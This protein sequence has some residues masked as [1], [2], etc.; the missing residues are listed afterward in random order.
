MGPFLSFFFKNAAPWLHKGG[1]KEERRREG[2]K[3]R[4]RQR[5]GEREKV[6]RERGRERNFCMLQVQ[7]PKD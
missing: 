7:L 4:G 1:K 3:E 5:D 2:E 6:T